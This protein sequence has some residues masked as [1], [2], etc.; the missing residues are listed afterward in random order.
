M[1]KSI[2]S[3]LLL[4]AALTVTLIYAPSNGTAFADDGNY[5]VVSPDLKSYMYLDTPEMVAICGETVAVY[6]SGLNKIFV[7]GTSAKEYDVD[8]LD[9]NE[10]I[11][12]MV[13]AGDVYI[14]TNRTRLYDLTVGQFV[15]LKGYD[16]TMMTAD[17]GKLYLYNGLRTAYLLDGENITPFP[18]EERLIMGATSFAVVDDIAYFYKEGKIYRLPLALNSSATVFAEITANKIL[19]FIGSV[20]A[21]TD[22]GLTIIYTDSRENMTYTFSEAFP[23]VNDIKYIAADRTN[24]AVLSESD[25]AAFRYSNTFNFI[26]SY[27]CASNAIGWYNN[28]TKITALG[29]NGV[30][31]WDKGNS[32]LNR[33]SQSQNF[34]EYMNYTAMPFTGFACDDYYTFYTDGSTIYMSDTNADK[35][36]SFQSVKTDFDISAMCVNNE[37][38]YVYD[39]LTG[40]VYY[41]E[42]YHY[43]PESITAGEPFKAA[44]FVFKPL[45]VSYNRIYDMK[46]AG[47]DNPVIYANTGSKIEMFSSIGKLNLSIDLGGN[48]SCFD[49]DAVG[50]VYAVSNSATSSYITKYTR[51]AG[52]FFD[53]HAYPSQRQ[54]PHRGD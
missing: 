4:V 26:E 42:Y 14:L 1:K 52:G 44:D 35:V 54:F 31:V 2:Y 17:N 40:G 9:D 5:S 7:S 49:V 19:P 36:E 6:D 50:N 43:Q 30:A 38:L 53:G 21:V 25:R 23:N 37:R 51:G 8:F 15:N 20:I 11:V 46:A 48:F 32:R 16:V 41:G 34:H 29:D 22:T 27:G 47:G 12:D 13:C 39:K 33:Y 28:P 10:S 45:F 24:I 3:L 18:D